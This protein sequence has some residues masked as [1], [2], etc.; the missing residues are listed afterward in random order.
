MKRIAVAI[1]IHANALVAHAHAI[2]EKPEAV[3]IERIDSLKGEKQFIEYE[4]CLEKARKHASGNSFDSSLFFYDSAFKIID[5][6]P[7]DYFEAFDLAVQA[8]NPDK[9]F[10]YL[11]S[12]AKCGLDVR[13]YSTESVTLF[14]RTNEYQKYLLRKDSLHQVYL[15]SIDTVYLKELELLKVEDQKNRSGD[16]LSLLTDSLN[17][18]RLLELID[19]SGFPTL[20]KVAF[21]YNIAYFLLWHHRDEYPDSDQWQRIL[22]IIEEEIRMGEIT[23]KFFQ[24]FDAVLQGNW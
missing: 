17:F 3:C 24:N 19:Q 2:S 5:F 11:C 14:L 23:P 7:Y 6:V 1:L 12:G 4:N 13:N 18:D 16:S 8:N 20:R 21:G 15:N 10:D 9:A 22:P